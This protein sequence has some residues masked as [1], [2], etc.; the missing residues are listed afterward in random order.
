MVV[1]KL[2]LLKELLH[3]LADL[4]TDFIELLDKFRKFFNKE[5]AESA[6]ALE[7]DKAIN[8]EE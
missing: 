8:P 1:E 7:E 5:G 3:K 4:V 6:E 2:N